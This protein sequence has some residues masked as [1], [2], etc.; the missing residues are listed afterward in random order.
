MPQIMTREQADNYA[1][2]QQSSFGGSAQFLPYSLFDTI[3]FPL[4]GTLAF[5]TVAQ[6][7]LKTQQMTNLKQ[8][9]Q[10]PVNQNFNFYAIEFSVKNLG[11][12]TA[13]QDT[14]LQAAITALQ[15]SSWRFVIDGREFETEFPG[16][17]LL[18][19]MVTVG[20]AAN[21]GVGRLT[22]RGCRQLGTTIQLS[23]LA[24]FR[25]EVS[26]DASAAASLTILNAA[27]GGQLQ[28]RLVGRLL[29]R[30]A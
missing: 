5:F 10:L 3:A 14:N 11:A 2:T 12:T 9:G 25:L 6:G 30:Q 23:K 4:A 29:R 19:S 28:V 20:A 1:V 13:A 7:G 17:E 15:A 27:A 8:A 24:P 16:A 18:P 21:A 22:S 26:F